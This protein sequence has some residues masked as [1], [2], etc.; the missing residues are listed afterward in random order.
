MF[1]FVRVNVLRQHPFNSPLSG[2]TRVS[3]YH[4][5]K[6]K[7]NPDF[8]EA[9]DSEWQWHQLDYMQVC[10]SLQIDYYTSIPPLSSFTGQI[11]L[12]LPNQWRQITEGLRVDVLITHIFL[13]F[14]SVN[15]GQF[16]ILL[17]TLLLLSYQCR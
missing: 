17:L 12:L 7:T 15:F 16:I 5:Q 6:G 9:R 1:A 2:S 14:Y 3:W 10:T 11:P 8:T 13:Y 4:Y